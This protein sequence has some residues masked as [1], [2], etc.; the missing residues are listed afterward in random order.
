MDRGRSE[1]AAAMDAA[2][3]AS[4]A[5]HEA[6]N[7]VRRTEKTPFIKF[8]VCVCT[9]YTCTLRNQMFHRPA[10][11]RNTNSHLITPYHSFTAKK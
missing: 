6:E 5:T 2:L 3:A 8:S 11:T 1:S 4:M 9:T 7:A 10:K